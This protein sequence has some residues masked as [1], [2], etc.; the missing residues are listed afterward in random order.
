MTIE[1]ISVAAMKPATYNP[2][3]DLKPG[4]PEYEH[5]RS[6]IEEFGYID[7]V[8]W[9]RRTGNIVGGHQRFKI[10]V[11]QG[12]TE[13]DA[14][15]VDMDEQTEKAANMALNKAVGLWDEEKVKALLEELRIGFDMGAFGFD[16]D[17]YFP[18]EAHEDDFDA[19]A[20]YA[21]IEE[22]ETKT[23]DLIILGSHRLLCGDSTKQKDM[24]RLMDGVM[25][26]LVV[27]D[28]PYNVNYG[29]TQSK[30]VEMHLDHYKG[31]NTDS[32]MNDNMDDSSFRLF[33]QDFFLNTCSHMRA[34]AGIY[35]FHAES[36]G[37]IF[38]ESFIAS[39]LKLSQ[40]LI[41]EKNQITL[42]FS[43]Y[44]W[45]HEPCLYGW[46]EGAAHFFIDD[47]T[48]S[49][50][51]AILDKDIEDMKKDELKEYAK[52]LKEQLEMYSSV[53][54]ENKPQKN[55]LHPTMKP[56]RLVGRLI[57]N[58]SKTG[59][60]VLDPFGGSGSTLIAAEEMGRKAYLMEMD[61][62]YCDVIVK[63]WE[64]LTGKKAER[65]PNTK[66]K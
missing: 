38:R 62:K 7:P 9:N 42:G 3:V 35:V 31:A 29:E 54:F 36:T 25:A 55:D 61:P 13:I 47:R 56:V 64:E 18:P 28:P 21:A 34:G 45:K 5:I 41:W 51:L 43:D 30:K 12:Y 37:H 53:I 65:M 33:L 32:I 52:Q 48:Q 46:K 20:V 58:S 24:D 57:G 17:K 27:T 2:R 66:N 11:E 16:M 26:D 15:V 49:T 6:S 1:R 40:C 4:D 19:E 44:Q 22:P 50:I 10:L 60:S 39:G 14:V 8:I 23:G 63:R 59:W